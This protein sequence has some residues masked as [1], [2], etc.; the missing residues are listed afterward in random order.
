MI[1]SEEFCI[2]PRLEEH[3][4]SIIQQEQNETFTSRILDAK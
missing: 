3:Q 2:F 4:L 1:H